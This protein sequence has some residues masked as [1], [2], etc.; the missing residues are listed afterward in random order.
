ML[1]KIQNPDESKYLARTLDDVTL[2]PNLAAEAENAGTE[3]IQEILENLKLGGP[4]HAGT[5]IDGRQV[6]DEEFMEHLW[7][8]IVQAYALKGEPIPLSVPIRM[9]NPQHNPPSMIKHITDSD[10]LNIPAEQRFNL[11]I[12]A[13]NSCINEPSVATWI[14][15]NLTSIFADMLLTDNSESEGWEK[16]EQTAQQIVSNNKYYKMMTDIVDFN[17][18]NQEVVEEVAM[19]EE[20]KEC[21]KT[22]TDIKRLRKD[23]I[24]LLEENKELLDSLDEFSR[25]F[26]VIGLLEEEYAAEVD[27]N[28]VFD[29]LDDINGN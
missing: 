2:E 19:V 16:S 26:K 13:A 9:S 10:I 21:V 25:D 8:T 29:L 17:N 28:I 14:R 6:S 20:I 7:T 11:I 23:I 27:Q 4:W 3:V 18:P 24:K 12:E 22:I 15:G 1:T 5:A